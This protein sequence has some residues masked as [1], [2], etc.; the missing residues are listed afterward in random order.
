MKP[1]AAWLC[2]LALLA[3]GV[4]SAQPRGWRHVPSITAVG[5]D[6]NDVRLGLLDEAVGFWNQ[7]FEALESGFRLGNVNR[8]VARV[9]DRDLQALSDTVL[10]RTGVPVT[11]PPVFAELP[12]DIV[13]ALSD[14]EFVSFA[15][16]FAGG[17]RR[18]VAIKGMTYPPFTLRNVARNVIAHEL[19]HALGLGHNGDSTKLMCGRPAPCRPSLF[20][21]D[22]PRFFPLTD[23]EKRALGSM[24]PIGWKSRN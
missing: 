4:A 17:S 1:A 22:T 20:Q 8:V 11:V 15:A 9:P 21:S 6:A 24:Y 7:T 12:G 23:D 16:P 2:L 18:I 14:S 10:A 13:V 5:P 19:G 3:A